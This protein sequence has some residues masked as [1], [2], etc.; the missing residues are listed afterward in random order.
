MRKIQGLLMFLVIIIFFGIKTEHNIK[1]VNAINFKNKE[2]IYKMTEEKKELFLTFDI[3]WAEDDKTYE[4]LEILKENDVKGTFFIMGKW[5]IYPD[6]NKEKLEK[7]KE[8]G[9]IIGNHSY[10]HPD[11]KE[12]SKERMEKEILETE[13]IIID[14]IGVKTEIFRFPSGSFSEKAVET[15]YG[16]GYIPIEWN[17]DSKDW[18]NEGLEKEY[19]NV[20][21]KLKNGSIILYHN[22]GRHTPENIRRLIKECKKDG[23]TFGVLKN[24]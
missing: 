23:Y 3:N 15:V 18:R 20:K 13:K 21:K 12:I 5:V 7:I 4:I 1:F 22:N 9:H 11:F 16:L 17:I 10:I 8:E 14:T 2:P 6:G 19:L 24:S